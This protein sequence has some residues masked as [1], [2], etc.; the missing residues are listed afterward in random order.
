ML[1]SLKRI[2]VFPGRNMKKEAEG[3]TLLP[4]IFMVAALAQTLNSMVP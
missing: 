4:L 1:F 3:Q 2:Y